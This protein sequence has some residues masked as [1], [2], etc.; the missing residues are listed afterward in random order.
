MANPLYSTT[1]SVDVMN[2]QMVKALAHKSHEPYNGF[3][4]TTWL[5]EEMGKASLVLLAVV[6]ACAQPSSHLDRR[7]FNNSWDDF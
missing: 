2:E 3:C 1:R 6:E 5:M 7:V 4:D